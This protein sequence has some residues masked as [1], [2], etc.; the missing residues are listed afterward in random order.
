MSYGGIYIKK[1]NSNNFDLF[2]QR[3]TQL[4]QS[5]SISEHTKEN[6]LMNLDTKFVNS[7]SFKGPKSKFINHLKTQN[8]E[9][10]IPLIFSDELLGIIVLSKKFSK[11]DFTKT[12]IML[13]QI[14]GNCLSSSLKNSSLLNSLISQKEKLNKTLFELETFFDTGKLIQSSDSEDQLFEDLLIR[15]VSLLNASGGVI[16][17]CQTGSPICK[18]GASIHPD[19]SKLRTE[20]FTTNFEP[21]KICSYKKSVLIK[22][23][24]KDKKLT[25]LGWKNLLVSPLV[26]PQKVHGFL[27]L[28]EKETRS[29]IIHFSVEDSH[30]LEVISMQAG[31]AIENM[32][33]IQNL[34]KE[35]KSVKNIIRSIG[36]GIITLN[37][38][39]EVDSVNENT[40][41][42][43][44][45]KENELLNHSYL[46]LFEN[47]NR[48]IE[49]TTKCIETG[50]SVLE[51]NILLNIDNGQK[52]INFTARP[53]IDSNQIAIGVIIGLENITEELRVRN[54][55]KRYVSESIVDQIIEDKLELAMGGK[56]INATILFA[57]IRGFTTLSEKIEPDEVVE[58]LNHYFTEMIEIIFKNEGTLDKIVGDELM[59]VYGSPIE[60]KNAEEKAVKTAIEM[61]NKLKELNK[62]LTHPIEIGIGINSGKVISGNIGSEV[63]SDFTVIGDNV[64]LAARLCSFANAKE[65]II[66]E[67]TKNNL[68]SNQ[69]TKELPP[70][71]VKGKKHKISAFTVK[72]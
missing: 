16:Y 29:G 54:T 65:I 10:L 8:I 1:N 21:F 2:I 51:Q 53:L 30:I 58:L 13:I 23:D 56:L 31:I 6:L 71:Y 55:F 9:I 37:L 43:L 45:K 44:E 42:I 22:N 35:K 34:E 26:G 60:I 25:K 64:N 3:N 4:N 32:L 39:G 67:N 47:N 38:I 19:D 61:Q 49:L 68:S 50:E 27:I 14:M 17:L 18:I 70:F 5:V 59:V 57:D 66:S 7:I 40:I 62:I 41:K 72:F 36:S 11:E 12:D 33:L 15:A 63:R 24:V 20:L 48:L 69:I 52:N 28:G 46:F